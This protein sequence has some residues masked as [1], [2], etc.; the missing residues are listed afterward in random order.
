M[1]KKR[2]RNRR[3]ISLNFTN[4]WLLYEGRCCCRSS[5]SKPFV[6]LKNSE[7]QIRRKRFV[8]PLR[9]SCGIKQKKTF[10][11]F[12]R[13]AGENW[14]IGTSS[15]AFLHTQTLRERKRDLVLN[16]LFCTDRKGIMIITIIIIKDNHNHFLSPLP[17]PPLRFVFRPITSLSR[18]KMIRK[19]ANIFDAPTEN[20]V[21]TFKIGVEDNDIQDKRQYWYR[22]QF[23]LN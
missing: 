14:L 16:L 23:S 5:E 22:K 19:F 17:P 1:I 20:V 6:I 18:V 11:Y 21:Q 9:P 10:K 7:F 12:R 4:R 8:V 15:F 3:N 13:T 2:N